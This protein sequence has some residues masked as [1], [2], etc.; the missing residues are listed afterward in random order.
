MRRPLEPIKIVGSLVAELWTRTWPT[1]PSE[2]AIEQIV[3][4][5]AAF[6]D[7]PNVDARFYAPLQNFWMPDKVAELELPTGP[8][9]KR[10]DDDELAML[11]GSWTEPAFRHSHEFALVGDVKLEKKFGDLPP[12][13]QR[14]VEKP[15]STIRWTMLGLRS[16]KAG[17]VDYNS[18]RLCA[19]KFVPFTLGSDGN[20]DWTSRP[21]YELTADE[22]E[23]LREHLSLFT[24]PLHTTLERACSRLALAELRKH[25]ADKLLDAAIGLEAILLYK[26]GMSELNHRLALNY[27]TLFESPDERRDAY[28]KAKRVYDQRSRVSHGE[29][30]DPEK[31]R[32][33]ASDSCEMLR[34][35]VKTFLPDG[36]T[37]RYTPA[38]WERRWFGL[39]PTGEGT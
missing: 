35:V 39:S 27:S 2:T 9:I 37:P 29:N 31:V 33:A 18:V 10:L 30:T 12:D 6:L 24:G 7:E 3:E 8:I 26:A 4:E 11:F 23:P 22:L 13:E 36:T 16:F 32:V 38:Y 25:Q 17:G 19:R 21:S 1:T 34:R 15:A 20:V 28:K 14:C 5:F